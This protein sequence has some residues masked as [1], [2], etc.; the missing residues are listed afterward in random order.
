LRW[1]KYKAKPTTIDGVRFPSKKEARR[2][3]QL[4]LLLAAGQIKNL[5]LQPQYPIHVAGS[6]ICT[7]IADFRYIDR[8]GVT[9]VEDVKGVETPVFRLKKKLVEAIYGLKLLI[10]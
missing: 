3:S 7:Y 4:K 2:Y 10:T 5:E 8:S 1:S 9:I 6:K